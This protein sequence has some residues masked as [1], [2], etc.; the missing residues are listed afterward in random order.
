MIHIFSDNKASKCY[1]KFLLTKNCCLKR[2]KILRSFM[3]EISHHS[4]EVKILA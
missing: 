3:A 4:K 2:E 1:E